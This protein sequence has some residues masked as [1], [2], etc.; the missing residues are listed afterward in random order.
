MCHRHRVATKIGHSQLVV[1]KQKNKK[2]GL[3]WRFST[4]P[5][6]SIDIVGDDFRDFD[7]F[8]EGERFPWIL[9]NLVLITFDFHPA[10]DET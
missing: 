10:L 3:K 8:A 9:G 5:S 1:E 2:R 4:I 6:C 7:E